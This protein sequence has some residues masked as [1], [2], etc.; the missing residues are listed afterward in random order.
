MV[1]PLIDEF[2]FQEDKKGEVIEKEVENI[3]PQI[4]KRLKTINNIWKHF[5]INISKINKEPRSTSILMQVILEFYIDEILEITQKSKEFKK[6]PYEDKIE[7]L[8][9]SNILDSIS[10]DD[11]VIVYKIRNIYAHELIFNEKRVWDRLKSIKSIFDLGHYLQDNLNNCIFRILSIFMKR[12]QR[13]YGDIL[14][15]EFKKEIS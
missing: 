15:E 7:K 2:E 4:K 13:I 6:I 8:K 1:I 10:C 5:E 11:L 3:P 12:I 14:L 9:N